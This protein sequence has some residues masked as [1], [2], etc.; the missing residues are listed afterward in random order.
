M[1][2]TGGKV[3]KDAEIMT[4]REESDRIIVAL[5][6]SAD[7]AIVLGEKLAG[8]ARW[9]K[10]G[11]TLYYAVGPAIIRSLH[12]LGFKVFLDLKLHDIPNTVR[13][14]MRSLAALGADKSRAVYVGDSEVDIETARNAGIPC[15]SVTWGFRDREQLVEAKATELAAD[16]GELHALLEK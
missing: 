5:D 6:C 16:A 12:K 14:G 4:W 3:G 8:H 2:R 7:E 11:M 9:V 15:I 13:G 10:V 1:R